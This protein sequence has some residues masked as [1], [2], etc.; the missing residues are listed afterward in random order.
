MKQ[1][2]SPTFFLKYVPIFSNTTYMYGDGSMN[3][4]QTLEE[5][6]NIFAIVNGLLIWIYEVTFK[7][8]RR[9]YLAKDL[10]CPCN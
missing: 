9:E 8:W 7:C 2:E 5:E 6:N 10:W 1:L 3:N 4:N